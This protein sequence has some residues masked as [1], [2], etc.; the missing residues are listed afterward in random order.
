MRP[1]QS[2]G[3]K[4]LL[5]DAKEY[6]GKY[7]HRFVH[8]EYLLLGL[9]K[10]TNSATKILRENG[11]DCRQLSETCKKQCSK[12]HHDPEENLKLTPR[13]QH[14]MALAGEQMLDLGHK[15]LDS[16]H[17]M[18]G[19]IMEE[20]GLGGIVLREAGLTPE[21]LRNIILEEDRKL[22]VSDVIDTPL[23]KTSMISRK[24]TSSM[25]K[26]WSRT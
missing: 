3:V 19:L 14:V 22:L 24:S 23:Q 15:D 5:F 12:G 21:I 20:E 1:I 2:Q 4:Q 16:R 7:N 10:H 13:A 11:F 26:M 18:L 17:I 9:L 25:W 6:A 8:T